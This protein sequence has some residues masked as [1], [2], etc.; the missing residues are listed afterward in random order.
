MVERKRSFTHL[1]E[2]T[3]FTPGAIG[4][5]RDYAR[6][7]HIFS[8][9]SVGI[10]DCD[11]IDAWAPFEDACE[12]HDVQPV[13]GVTLYPT[14]DGYHQYPV[15][16]LVQ[17]ARGFH[18]IY[19]IL[20]KQLKVKDTILS[21]PEIIE[22]SDGVIVIAS[23]PAHD[24]LNIHAFDPH[25][26]FYR[27]SHSGDGESDRQL[28]KDIKRTKE[29]QVQTVAN[30]QVW[31]AQPRRFDQFLSRTIYSRKNK[32]ILNPEDFA[33]IGFSNNRAVYDLLKSQH[34]QPNHPEGW[35][36]S[37]AMMHRLVKKE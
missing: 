23:P 13:F 20:H 2:Q 10:A 26:L 31:K 37:P 19:R 21:V 27:L 7:A 15:S 25:R 32:R 33:T 16:L 22:H 1:T 14:V 30:N 36:K 29:L 6:A 11:T 8:M 18:D 9:S 3:G 24:V 35:L 34:E 4:T 5:E 12:T 28:A 17:D